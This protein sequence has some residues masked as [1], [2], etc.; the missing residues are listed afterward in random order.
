MRLP[1]SPVFRPSGCRSRPAHLLWANI[2][3]IARHL[4][5]AKRHS[6]K[7]KPH[8]VSPC[9]TFRLLVEA[10]ASRRS[11]GW[12]DKRQKKPHRHGC[13]QTLS[14]WQCDGPFYREIRLRLQPELLSL[15]A[16][17]GIAGAAEAYA[18]RH[19]RHPHDH[20][21]LGPA[22][23]MSVVRAH[24]EWE[25]RDDQLPAV[26]AAAHIPRACRFE[27]YGVE[28]AKNML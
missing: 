22:A 23:G 2:C 7:W 5:H 24:H 6:R 14:L 10:A 21:I 11:V 16:R 12:M 1:L 15:R 13:C 4:I 27:L 28:V 18:V 3:W 17:R 9:E 25:K 8:V 19:S 20:H 26:D